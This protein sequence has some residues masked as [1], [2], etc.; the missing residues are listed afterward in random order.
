[1]HVLLCDEA[2]ILI[3]LHSFRPECCE[4]YHPDTFEQAA[5]TPADGAAS[6]HGA[7]LCWVLLSFAS[8]QRTVDIQAVDGMIGPRR[9][10]AMP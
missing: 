3:T 8:S 9:T 7:R 2:R 4:F 10:E 5:P 1:V 6:A